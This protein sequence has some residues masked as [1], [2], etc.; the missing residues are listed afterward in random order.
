M[1]KIILIGSEGVL[2]KFYQQK[3]SS[4]NN[5]LVSA[6]IKI[7]KKKN[8]KNSLNFKLNLE[9]ENEI[10]KFFKNIKKKFGS[11]DILINN[12][13]LT[14][15]GI[16]K[17]SNKKVNKENYDT[18]IWDKT[19]NIN[20]RGSFLSCKYFLKYHHNKKNI[21]KI[22]NIGSI[23]GSNSPHHDI[24]NDESFFSSLAYTT[25]KSGLI[26]MTKWLATKYAKE[27][28]YCNMI[29]PAGVKNNQNKKWQKKYLELIPIGKMAEPNNIFGALEYLL[30][31]NSNYMTGQNLHIDGGFSSW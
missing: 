3:L 5:F 15:E 1:K 4:K 17:I 14:T 21:Q 7:S 13:A 25:S 6:D 10:E 11:F 16:K 26:G 18:F 27:K 20:L 28:T 24:Y 19:I 23:Y 30:S 8:S 22:I 12:A 2:G 31:N 29:S 9:K